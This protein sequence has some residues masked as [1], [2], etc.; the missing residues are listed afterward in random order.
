MADKKEKRH[1][2]KQKLHS[3]AQYYNA[4]IS[5]VIQNR[6]VM[7]NGRYLCDKYKTETEK[8]KDECCE[9]REMNWTP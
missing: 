3:I 2:K 9:R 4:G 5:F 7:E 1:K 6:S 8:T